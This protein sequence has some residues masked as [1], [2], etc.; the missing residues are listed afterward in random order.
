MRKSGVLVE[1]VVEFRTRAGQRARL[2]V[3]SVTD[4]AA[5]VALDNAIVAAGRGVVVRPD[6][7]RNVE[8]EARRI[9]D[10]YRGFSAG[11]A[12]TSVVA[13][14]MGGVPSIVGLADLKQLRPGLVRHVA[15]LSV[16]VH[17]DHQRHGIGRRLMEALVDHARSFGLE[18]LELYVRA[19]NP[20]ARAL[21]A[22]LG[23]G[24]EAT[25]RRFIKAVDGSYVDDE[26]WALFLDAKS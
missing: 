21:Y 11:E 1:E 4:A 24:H 10:L 17:P 16:G 8:L 3:A 15:T 20:R 22:S 23:F 18:R 9:D 13:E 5:I 6:E 26:I 14:L 12:T 2:R 19:D 7:L 25:R